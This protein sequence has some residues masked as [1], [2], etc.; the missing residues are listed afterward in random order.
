MQ[1]LRS[2]KHS[3]QRLYGNPGNIVP[4]LLRGQRYS[5]G[6]GVEAHQPGAR[7]LGAEAVFHDAIPDLAR[8][9]ILGDLLEEVVVRVE[10]EAQART[11]LIHIQSA[12]A[13]PFHVLDAVI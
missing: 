6:L 13:R 5:R 7:V 10:E 1:G 11:K 9:A 8:G 3:G 2:S 4:G 12:V